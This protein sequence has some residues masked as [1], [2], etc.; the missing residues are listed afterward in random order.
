MSGSRDDSQK[1]S[2]TAA[3][4]A[5]QATA[6]G[7]NTAAQNLY[8]QTASNTAAMADPNALNVSAPT[9]P[10]KLQFNAAVENTANQYKDASGQLARSM[11]IRGF[12]ADSPSGM[13]AQ[14]ERELAADQ[15]D[16]QGANFSNYTNQSY[17]TALNNF[18]NANNMG[19]QNAG[20]QGSLG[21]QG[22]DSAANTYANLYA[23]SYK[24]S[25]WAT[26]GQIAGGV[27]GAA[28]GNGGAVSKM[29]G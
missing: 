16:A 27:A 6:S 1:T 15:A 9:G 23:N 17:Q 11:A 4:N 20:Q 26:V 5:N 12:G 7:Y 3:A 13:Q 2:A 22:G 29:V 10:S 24:P 19:S 28:L 25:A 14:G 21:T 18:W 8:G